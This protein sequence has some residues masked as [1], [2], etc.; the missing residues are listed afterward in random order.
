MTSSATVIMAVD[1]NRRN[2]ELLAQVLSRAGYQT[3]TAH[4]LEEFDQALEETPHASLALVDIAGFD[5]GVWQRCQRLHEMGIPLLI[6][7]PRTAAQ[8]ESIGHGARG[9][10]AKPLVVKELLGLIRGMVED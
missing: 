2:L 5:R 6:I 10:L 9:V 7:S 1:R 3:V 8:S 4:S